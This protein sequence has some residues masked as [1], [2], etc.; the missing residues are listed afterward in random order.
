MGSTVPFRLNTASEDGVCLTVRDD[1]WR[2][3]LTGAR[4]I[5]RDWFVQMLALGPQACTFT[6]RVTGL[7]YE[8]TTARRMLQLVSESLDGAPASHVYLEL[9]DSV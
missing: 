6:I 7:P 4:R 3:H 1:R 9:H 8:V 2:V 5:G